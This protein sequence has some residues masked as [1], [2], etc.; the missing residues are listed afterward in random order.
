MRFK[1]VDGCG[2]MKWCEADKEWVFS[3]PPSFYGRNEE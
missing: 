3:Y 2:W 1:F